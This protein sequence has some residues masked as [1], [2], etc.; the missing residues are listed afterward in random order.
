MSAPV[1]P[2]ITPDQ[3][4]REGIPLDAQV[5]LRTQGT[6][7]SY[8]AIPRTHLL[9]Q[10]PP[11]EV[12]RNIARKGRDWHAVHQIDLLFTRPPK[13]RIVSRLRLSLTPPLSPPDITAH[14]LATPIAVWARAATDSV[15]REGQPFS[16]AELLT[17]TCV[18]GELHLNDT[19]LSGPEKNGLHRYHS[20]VYCGRDMQMD[21][22]SW[23]PSRAP[24]AL[25][26]LQDMARHVGATDPH[27]TVIEAYWNAPDELADILHAFMR[28]FG[29]AHAKAL[30]GDS[31]LQAVE[32]RRLMEELEPAFN[33]DLRQ[34]LIAF[35]EP[36]SAYG[37]L[38]LQKQDGTSSVQPDLR[39]PPR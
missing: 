32:E 26:T 15:L 4:Q 27:R 25:S 36:V 12:F 21:E 31:I 16:L 24:N 10:E 29:L 8:G 9:G 5:R 28:R 19:V 11:I 2:L 18:E 6:R 39:A 3:L 38:E 22:F 23:L 35:A 33:H 13:S 14:S 37:Q 30:L 1:T 7:V 20:V 34:A 17:L